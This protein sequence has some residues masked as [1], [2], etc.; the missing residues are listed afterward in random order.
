LPH[1]DDQLSHTQVS[2]ERS[3]NILSEPSGDQSPHNQGTEETN[4]GGDLS[5]SASRSIQIVAYFERRTVSN[6][7][8]LFLAN[9]TDRVIE[10]IR[11][12]KR[13]P[14]FSGSFERRNT[15]NFFA[16]C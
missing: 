4:I 13:P 3:K 6:I 12:Y 5:N 9:Y 11:T 10:N 14:T 16:I 8:A 2:E 1:I 7:L 15:Y